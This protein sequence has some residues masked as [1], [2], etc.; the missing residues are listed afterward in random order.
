MYSQYQYLSPQDRR[1]PHSSASSSRSTGVI[2]PYPQEPPDPSLEALTR[3]GMTPAQAY[4]AQVYSNRPPHA[5]AV[6]SQL[7][8]RPSSS[9]PEN[10]FPISSPDPK[11]PQ[12]DFQPTGG[13]LDIEFGDNSQLDQNKRMNGNA[14][15]HT[16]F[17]ILRTH[18]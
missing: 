17:F 12:L 7:S 4:Q 6:Q 14:G 8:H 15:E 13:R 2:A 5:P 16:C 10:K 1:Y 9:S 18:N 11:I 3:S